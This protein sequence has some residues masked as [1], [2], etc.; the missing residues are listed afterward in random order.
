[1]LLFYLNDIPLSLRE[2]AYQMP[3]PAHHGGASS[4]SRR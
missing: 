3:Q 4:A 1:M 2:F